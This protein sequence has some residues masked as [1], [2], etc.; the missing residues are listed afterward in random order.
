MGLVLFPL[1]KFAG[2]HTAIIGAPN[3]KCKQDSQCKLKVP[4]RHI[5]ATIVA[6]EKQ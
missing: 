4:L 3:T 5:R 2:S 1:Q 6:V